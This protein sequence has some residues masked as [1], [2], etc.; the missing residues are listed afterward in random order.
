MFPL[1]TVLVPGMPLSLNVFEPRYRKLVADLLNDESPAAPQFGVV[2]LRAGW[3]VGV[4]ADVYR[5]GTTARVSEVFPHADGR[6]RIEATGQRR[7][8]ILELDT[9]SQPYLIAKV[10]FLAE[11]L[12]EHAAE[13]AP[14]LAEALARYKEELVGAGVDPSGPIPNDPLEL[15]YSAA[16][17]PWLTVSDRQALLEAPDATRRLARAFAIVRRESTLLSA[18]HAVPVSAEAL[19]AGL[20]SG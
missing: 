18:L 6:C 11:D 8:E 10:R 7:F 4:L 13:L 12:G 14:R 19:R 2:A 1:R 16:T 17:Q 20:S 15:S 5:V 9:K 3:E